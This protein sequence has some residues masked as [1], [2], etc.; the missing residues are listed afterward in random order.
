ASA[1]TQD[2]LSVSVDKA[3]AVVSEAEAE[4]SIGDGASLHAT[5]DVTLHATGISSSKVTTTRAGWGITYGSSSPTA[6]ITV[7][8][9]VFIHADNQVDVNA[10]VDNTLQVVTLVPSLGL[11]TSIAVALGIAHSNSLAD[12]QWGSN[13]S[14][15]HMAVNATNSN[16]FSNSAIAAGFGT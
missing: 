9:G 3:I 11:S 15:D 1:S 10:H 16:F 6:T 8:N 13:I 7:A 4:I 5:H 2:P 14:A 12:V